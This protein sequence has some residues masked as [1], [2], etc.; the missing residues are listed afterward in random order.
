MTYHLMIDIKP[1]SKD[2]VSMNLS[3]SGLVWEPEKLDGKIRIHVNDCLMSEDE[4]SEILSGLH[5]GSSFEKCKPVG[6]QDA[7]PSHILFCEN[8]T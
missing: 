1:T 6:K 2:V 3:K 7:T 4:V 5:I 8:D